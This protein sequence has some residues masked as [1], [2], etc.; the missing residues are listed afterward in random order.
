MV[1]KNFFHYRIFHLTTSFAHLPV[2][3]EGATNLRRLRALVGRVPT[4]PATKLSDWRAHEPALRSAP[5]RTTG[6][7]RPHVEALS[8]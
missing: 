8:R 7:E 4:H 6:P 2:Q 1:T 3:S 5:R